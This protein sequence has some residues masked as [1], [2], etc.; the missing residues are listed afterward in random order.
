MFSYDV[1]SIEGSTDQRC[2]HGKCHDPAVR[3]DNSRKPIEFRNPSITLL[4]IIF[5]L[6]ILTAIIEISNE[7][8]G[9]YKY[10]RLSLWIIQYHCIIPYDYKL[11]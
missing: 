1:G 5:I 11:I 2:T 9:R 10:E 6:D 8:N 7:R 4:N 3:M